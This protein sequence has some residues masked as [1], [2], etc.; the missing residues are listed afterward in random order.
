MTRPI[1]LI[2]V[3]IFYKKATGVQAGLAFSEEFK[4]CNVITY[5]GTDWI[6]VDFDRTGL[7]TRRIKCKDGARLIRNLRVVQDIIAIISVAIAG[8][9]PVAWKPFWVRSCNEVCRYAAGIDLGFT[10]NPIHLYSK[11]L[12]YSGKRNYEMLSAWR[13]QHGILRRRQRA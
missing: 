3:F 10:F 4:H 6:M 2:A 1:D 13:R 12:K 11:L 8:R 9:A 7:L 5:D